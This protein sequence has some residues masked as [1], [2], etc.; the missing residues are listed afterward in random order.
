[1]ND[2]RFYCGWQSFTSIPGRYPSTIGDIGLTLAGRHFPRPTIHPLDQR[3]LPLGRQYPPPLKTLNF[4]LKQGPRKIGEPR[5]PMIFGLPGGSPD[6]EGALRPKVFMN[7]IVFN[8][9][10]QKVSENLQPFRRTGEY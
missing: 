10:I 9:M 5:K 2:G 3:V 8:L 1:M 4:K 6:L 7:V